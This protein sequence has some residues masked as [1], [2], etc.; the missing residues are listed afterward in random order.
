MRKR[1][2]AIETSEKSLLGYATD[3][4]WQGEK[5]DSKGNWCDQKNTMRT[6]YDLLYAVN[7]LIKTLFSSRD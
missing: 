7:I 5:P 1:G 2:T 4:S 6:D 3:K